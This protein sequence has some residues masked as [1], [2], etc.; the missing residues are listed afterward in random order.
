MSLIGYYLRVI[1]I[2]IINSILKKYSLLNRVLL[3][4]TNNI[5][6]N[7]TL[8]KELNSYI[9]KIIKKRFFNNIIIYI[10]CLIYII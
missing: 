9:N 2:I 10:L 6:N 5:Y 4:T 1:F 3:I 7:S 8:I